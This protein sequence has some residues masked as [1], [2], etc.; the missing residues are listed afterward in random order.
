MVKGITKVSDISA[1]EV[2]AKG[3][4]PKREQISTQKAFYIVEKARLKRAVKNG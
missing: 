1:E 3:G 4:S 2:E